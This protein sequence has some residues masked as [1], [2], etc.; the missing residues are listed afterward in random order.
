[1]ICFQLRSVRERIQL[2]LDLL[3]FLRRFLQAVPKLEL[4]DVKYSHFAYHGQQLLLLDSDMI[5]PRSIVNQ[6]I[7]STPTCLT[8]ADCHFIDCQG[9]CHHGGCH[10]NPL[11]T[12]LKR[13]CRNLLFMGNLYGG[14]LDFGLLTFAQPEASLQLKAHCFDPQNGHLNQTDVHHLLAIERILGQIQ[15]DL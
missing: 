11:D 4:C 7:V 5:Y 13:L 1:M 2:A 3:Q 14:L 15:A 12:D 10:L 9:V 8:D 6:S